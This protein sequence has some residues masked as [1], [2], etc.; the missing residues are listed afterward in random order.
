MYTFQQI[1]NVEKHWRNGNI[2][3][4]LFILGWCSSLAVRWHRI[5]AERVGRERDRDRKRAE[6]NRKECVCL[7]LIYAQRFH[8]TFICRPNFRSFSSIGRIRWCCPF[9]CI[10]F[11][12]CLDTWI[13]YFDNM[14]R[15]IPQR[16]WFGN[17]F[18]FGF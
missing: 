14:H 17:R 8:V 13:E 1:S 16:I 9:L 6:K 4:I 11:F 15:N 12:V 5:E 3:A 10:V 18:S 7:D 2:F